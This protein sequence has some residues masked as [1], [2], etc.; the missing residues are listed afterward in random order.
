VLKG[1]RGDQ[2]VRGSEISSPSE[3]PGPLGNRAIDEDFIEWRQQTLDGFF[4]R[5]PPGKE[6][7]A[8]DDGVSDALASRP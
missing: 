4:L 2:G 7:A 8:C 3:S 1:G 6:L 5:L